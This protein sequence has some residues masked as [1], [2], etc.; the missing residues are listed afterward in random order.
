LCERSGNSHPRDFPDLAG[1]AWR[2]RLTRPRSLV[3]ERATAVAVRALVGSRLIVWG[4]GLVALAVFGSKSGVFS[5]MDARHLTQPFHSAAA[6]FAVA[7]AA[8]WDSVWYLAI[9][10]GGYSSPVS[11]AFFPAVPPC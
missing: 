9:A 2:V 11:S 6:N 1:G 7:T 8:R 5:A 10:N 3:E 4:A